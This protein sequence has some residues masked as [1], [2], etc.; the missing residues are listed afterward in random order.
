MNNMKKNGTLQRLSVVL[1]L[2]LFM[3]VA[4][5]V[6]IA[7]PNI[8]GIEEFDCAPS[9]STTAGTPDP[10]VNSVGAAWDDYIWNSALAHSK[11]SDLRER[12]IRRV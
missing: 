2:M 3:L 10:Q 12:W 4:V 8:I 7:S 5:Y 1:V 11:H 6:V 9:I